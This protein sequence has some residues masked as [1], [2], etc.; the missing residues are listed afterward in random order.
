MTEVFGP[1]EDPH[2]AGPEID[3]LWLKQTTYC[4]PGLGKGGDFWAPGSGIRFV[5]FKARRWSN[6]VRTPAAR[7]QLE[8]AA[9]GSLIRGDVPILR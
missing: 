1:A 4:R 9:G 5:F 2:F 6:N 8:E 7:I 3:F